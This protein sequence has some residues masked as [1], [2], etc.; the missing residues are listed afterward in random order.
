M[1]H[2]AGLHQL[3]HRPHGLLDL[4]L[5][6]DAMQVIEIDLLDAQAL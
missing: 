4:D 6:V 3:G 1:A 2:L 5:R